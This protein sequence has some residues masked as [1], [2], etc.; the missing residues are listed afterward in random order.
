MSPHAGGSF[1]RARVVTGVL[2]AALL[3]GAPTHSAGR[4][5][6]SHATPGSVL[7]VRLDLSAVVGRTAPG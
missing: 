4:L 1:R 3:A 7:L 6:S 5:E 2:A